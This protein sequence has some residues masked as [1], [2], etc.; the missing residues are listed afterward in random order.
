MCVFTHHV[1]NVVCD[2]SY[3]FKIS[4]RAGS[5]EGSLSLLVAEEEEEQDDKDKTR[6]ESHSVKVEEFGEYV[7]QMHAK[8]NNGFF[9]QFQVHITSCNIVACI[10]ACTQP[11]MHLF[12]AVNT[13]WRRYAE[14]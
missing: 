2:C 12:F 13:N 9:N 1:M 4:N 3:S 7:A 11:D 14:H 8:N 10:R 6:L 5:V